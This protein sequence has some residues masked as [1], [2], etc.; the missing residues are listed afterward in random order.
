[1]PLYLIVLEASKYKVIHYLGVLCVAKPT[2]SI[3]PWDLVLN[4][5]P[6]LMTGQGLIKVIHLLI[7]EGG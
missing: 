4:I 3:L 5:H 1:M 2:M 6:K 7:L